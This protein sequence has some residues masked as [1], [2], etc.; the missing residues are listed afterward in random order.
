MGL[1]NSIT[2]EINTKNIVDVL[3][4][5]AKIQSDKIAYTFLSNK[6]NSEEH[7]TYEELDLHARTIAAF[8][9]DIKAEGKRAL[10]LYPSCL[11]YIIAFMGCLYAKVIAVPAYP[12]HFRRINIRLNMIIENCKA[13]IILTNDNVYNKRHFLER[14]NPDLYLLH[15]INTS[16]LSKIDIKESKN[17]AKQ[18]KVPNIEDNDIAFLQY[19]SGST[20]DPKGVMVSHKNLIHNQKVIKRAFNTNENKVSVSWLPFFHDMG[21]I[22]MI[23]GSLFS[24][25]HSVL[26]SPADFIQ[27]PL[28]WLQA[29]SK[30]QANISGGPNFAYDLCV[31]KIPLKECSNLDLS[32]WELAFNGS[33]P[34][35]AETMKR[36]T[37]CFNPY[38]FSSKAF[39]SCYG[40][41]EATLFVTGG[42]KSSSSFPKDLSKTE[43][44]EYSQIESHEENDSKDTQYL[45]SSGHVYLD[46]AI[47]IVN[48]DTCQ[49]CPTGKIGEIW[50]S[51]PSVAQ[52][53]WKNSKKTHE[54]FKANLAD[55][56]N[57]YFLRT[58]DLGF[59]YNDELFVTGRLKNL[60]IL[61]GQNYYPQDIERT[62]AES[63]M[64]LKYSTTAA[65]SVPIYQEEQLI[66][67]QELSRHYK[68]IDLD[69]LIQNIRQE[70]SQTYGLFTYSVALIK[71]GS[72]PKT[73]SGK[74]QHQ[75]CRYLY[76]KRELP[77][78][79]IWKAD[80]NKTSKSISLPTFDRDYFF[81]ASSNKQLNLINSY[82]EMLI[83]EVLKTN[84][85][86]NINIE[87]PI[88]RF[89]LD[90]LK[91]IELIEHLERKLQVSISLVDL[92]EC[93]NLSELSQIIVASL[94]TT[95]LEQNIYSDIKSISRSQDLPL[96]FEQERLWFI[97]QFEKNTNA[98]NICGVI[99]FK[100]RFDY[101]ILKN[102]FQVIIDRHESLRTTFH[103]KNGK[104]IQKISLKLEIDIPCEILN[105]TKENEHSMITAIAQNEVRK[106]FDLSA[107]SPFRIKLLKISP[108]KH[109]LIIAIH[110]IIFDGISLNIF[111]KELQELYLHFLQHNKKSLEDLPI[112][113]ADFAFAQRQ[114]YSKYNYKEKLNYWKEKLSGELPILQLPTDYARPAHQTYQGDQQP[115]HLSKNLI[116]SL[117]NLS[118]EHSATLF[119]TLLSAFNILLFR[120]TQQTDIIIGMPTA[121][122]QH[123]D[124]RKLI[125]F[126][127]NTLVIR[128]DLSE[129]PCYIDFLK[130]IKKRTL[131]AYDHE[132][133]FEILSKEIKV[134]RDLRYPPLYQVMF[135]FQSEPLP[136][137]SFKNLSFSFEEINPT[138]SNCDLELILQKTEHGLEGYFRYNTDLFSSDR[139]T[140]MAKHF[141]TLLQ[142]ITKNTTERINEI[143]LLDSE[144]I[145]V[146][147]DWNK[148]DYDF[149]LD[150]TFSYFFNRRVFNNPENIAVESDSEILTY[151]E[152]KDKSDLYAK[153]I[154]KYEIKTP[155]L[156]G[157]LMNRDTD[158]LA[159]MIAAFTLG[160]AYIPLDPNHPEKRLE[161]I[162][163][164]AK[165]DFLIYSTENEPKINVLKNRTSVIFIDI[166]KLKS[167]TS[168]YDTNTSIDYNAEDRAY[169]MFTSGST[170]LP[171][172]AIIEQRGMMNH[173]FAKIKDL[174][175]TSDDSCIQNASHCFDISIWQFLCCLLQGGKV[176][177][178]NDDTSKDPLELL[179]LVN[180]EQ[181]TILEIVPSL[182]KAIF[183][184]Q[185]CLV[186]IKNINSLKVLIL[187]GEPLPPNLVYEWFK[188]RFDIPLLNAYGPTECSDDVTHYWIKKCPEDGL[189]N[190]PIG[191]AIPNAKLYVLDNK[192]KPVPIGVPGELYVG[193]LVVGQGYINDPK[194]T[195]NAFLEN[196]FIN[197]SY[198]RLYKTG[199]LV[200]YLAD[201]NLLFL[202]RID[203]QVKIRGFRIELEEIEN[204]MINSKYVKEALVTSMT[205]DKNQQT[206]VGY[207][208]AKEK[209]RF[210]QLLLKQYL[211][212]YL[213]EYMIPIH[214]VELDRFP[215]TPNGKID[216]N[217]LPSPKTDV[218][219][220]T[221]RHQYDPPTT[222]TEEKIFIIWSKLL[223]KDKVGINENF[224]ESGGYSLL[225]IEFQDKL[226]KEFNIDIRIAELFQHTTI[227]LLS[228]Y[229]DNS[230]SDVVE[231]E[232]EE[233]KI[234]KER[235]N[236]ALSRRNS[237]KK[238]REKEY[239]H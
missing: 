73:T 233:R 187:T 219:Y 192:M 157:I 31:E 32:F 67:I 160:S 106:P 184:N 134:Q 140:R 99:Y 181:I 148:T 38:G 21:L 156:I 93:Q 177:I 50:V 88:D 54:N 226:K 165:L 211:F 130:Q 147:N 136:A 128:S 190:V 110:H 26:M 115:L 204:I 33:E 175:I 49:E 166:N 89:G 20:S 96:S 180:N 163:K 36:F 176:R 76:L 215:L 138:T 47:R 62:V 159:L 150:K 230:L 35:Y 39:Y 119:M 173:L 81:K 105:C 18:I 102:A 11:E 63:H 133:P 127:A 118:K 182:L 70:I 231:V 203:N 189:V 19:T 120:Y 57:N 216:K 149:L 24:G 126:F 200:K 210:D 155:C 193:G 74:I 37:D 197:G 111:I 68:K 199:D 59:L 194:R 29:I 179:N 235:R 116:Q 42:R 85:K 5:R 15:W 139:M 52:G 114:Y 132:I 92:F 224:F 212:D 34:I 214:F 112:Q 13:S 137:L 232:I 90:S 7:I 86:S 154:L 223:N 14:N 44:Q 178:V 41:A 229:I 123:P 129:N 220:E 16:N 124:A 186:V 234:R 153:N 144:D 205:L 101:A 61:R 161:K 87:Q 100:G 103:N 40:L 239:S 201:G 125:G 97:Q 158:F 142:S 225:M 135:A 48:P 117:E 164:E 162:I 60:M 66:I 53:Y 208:V 107:H 145:K 131:E 207:I 80:I 167:I 17:L 185:Q 206:L 77:S 191:K 209:Q 43:L 55:D 3:A 109:A 45:I 221:I 10:L 46:T 113:Y 152:L 82:L 121:N 122:R 83:L 108:N 146:L 64:G 195:K 75:H 91:A 72:L 169:I 71:P 27:K 183:L 69:E 236:Y 171:K 151:Q 196:T 95:S 198:K 9:H 213:P 94:L 143:H 56:N 172:G 104:G 1:M 174:D 98:Y 22:G 28:R 217:K 78:V 23:I 51:S 168:N 8:L 170:G 228:K 4:S 202:G 25:V 58:G 218:I 65:F 84:D 222:S 30:Y 237:L 12:P 238:H 227:A 79:K 141:F 6:E 188:I 2:N